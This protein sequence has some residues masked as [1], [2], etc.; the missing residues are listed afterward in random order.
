MMV[1]ISTQDPAHDYAELTHHVKR[2]RGNAMLAPDAS[3]VIPVNAQGDL[4][5]VLTILSDIVSYDGGHTFEIVLMVN[6]YPEG[7][8][9]HE[10][11]TFRDMG[12]IIEAQP[13]VRRP[14]E[15]VGFTARMVGACAAC[16]EYV[17]LFDADCRIPNA[18]AVIDWYIDQLHSGAA[19]AYTHV[20]YYGLPDYPSIR[21]RMIAHHSARWFKR[22]VLRIPTTRGSNY[23][24]N[25]TLAMDCYENGMLADEMN[26]G[27]TLKHCGGCV[28]YSGAKEL[29]VLTSGRMFRPGWFRLC[30]YLVYRLRYNLRVLPIGSD[31][32]SRTK[33][34]NDP[35][36][37]YVN[38][39]P[40]RDDDEK[41]V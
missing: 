37:R 19:V 12:V 33:R 4:A 38:N 16:T 1:Q 39:V 22:V 32:A 26:V 29:V 11:A 8:E 15:A 40:V 28:A 34:E 10:T 27:P 14:G 41:A 20:D 2:I 31:V 23:A 25:R 5:N 35:V 36:R 6:N 13:N 3:V 24:F 21:F 9:P 7:S 17:I 30:R 18:T